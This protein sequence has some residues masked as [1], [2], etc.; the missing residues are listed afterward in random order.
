MEFRRVLFRSSPSAAGAV[1]RDGSRAGGGTAASLG[2][3][4]AG[5]IGGARCQ[6]EPGDGEDFP[7]RRGAQLQKKPPSRL[8]KTGRTWKSAELPLGNE[9]GSPGIS[10]S[11]AKY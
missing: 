1:R 6:G 10:G 11:P 4:A 2:Q 9:L 3:G 7:A 5:R 8:S